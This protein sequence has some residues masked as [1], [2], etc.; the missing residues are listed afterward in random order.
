MHDW[1]PV[2]LTKSI[3]NTGLIPRVSGDW[4]YTIRVIRDIMKTQLQEPWVCSLTG[5]IKNK[6]AKEHIS[7]QGGEIE[8]TINFGGK[9]SF[10]M[11]F[12]FPERL[13]R[14]CIYFHC[15]SVYT[16]IIIT[17]EPCTLNAEFQHFIPRFNKISLLHRYHSKRGFWGGERRLKDSVKTRWLYE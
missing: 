13:H 3:P 12:H 7:I 17:L 16:A 1:E 11:S 2:L 10:I 15:S 4:W 6:P 9:L 8:K 14:C 5:E